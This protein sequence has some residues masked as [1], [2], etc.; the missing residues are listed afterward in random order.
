MVVAA[1]TGAT[2]AY[3]RRPWAAHY[4]SSVPADAAV[5]DLSVPQLLTDAATTFPSAPA[6]AFGRAVTSYQELAA[7]VRRCAAALAGAGVGPGDRVAL[8]LPNCPQAVVTLYAVLHLGA[9][10]VPLNPLGSE[11]ETRE[12][13]TDCGARVVVC[14]DR[15][16]PLL[17][18]VR[19]AAGVER[20]VV[21]ALADALDPVRRL[22]LR[23][24]LPGARRERARLV[25]PAA[26]A[27]PGTDSWPAWLAAAG[28]DV[29]EAAVT[30]DDLAVLSYTTGTTGPVKAAALSHRNL[31]ANAYQCRWWLPEVEPGHEVTLGVL[32]LFHAYGLTLCV[33]SVASVGGLLV[34]LPAFDTGAVLEAID[35]YRPTLF[36]GVPPMYR[37]ILD[38]PAS[39][40]HDLSCLRV[41][42]SGAMPL[43]RSLQDRFEARLAGGVLIEGFGM[44]EASPVTHS[45]PI[46]GGRRT[47]C[48]GVPM[49]LTESLVV[50]P[51]DPMVTL[52]PGQAGELAVRGP[53]VC[54]SYWNRP[55]DRL[56]CTADGFLLTGDIAVMD[57]AG[58]FTVVDRKKDIVVAGGFNIAPTEVELVAASVP[59]V[60]D[61]CVL[62]VPDA[63]RGETLMAFVVPVAG[64]DPQALT[65]AVLTTCREQLAAY[66]VPT[67]VS[68]RETLP[69]GGVGKVL[70]RVLYAEEVARQA[71]ATAPASYPSQAPQARE[72]A[73]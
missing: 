30:G 65:D 45:V 70:R 46:S 17:E 51:D 31:V 62:G 72:G 52:P 8:L 47:G 48:I 4:P 55:E 9:V 73:S 61:V 44:T 35:T 50:D 22:G 13:L 54:A 6:L 58:F 28:P 24:P 23:L 29:P 38:D 40:D 57:E 20:V 67:A 2:E 56:P 36:P 33:T 66:K 63:Y 49:P 25:A 14:L 53:Q 34:L 27:G 64:A 59:G 18:R 1:R 60:A 21:T 71:A 32:P 39:R 10:A 12:L 3:A 26:T 37:A 68:I 41:C 42:M 16:A 19:A 69:R 7:R 43:P 5:P 11:P 15:V